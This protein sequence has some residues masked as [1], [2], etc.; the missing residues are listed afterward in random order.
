MARWHTF[1]NPV[2]EKAARVTAGLVVV[3]ALV[4]LVTRTGWLLWPMAL[5][6]ALRVYAGPRLSPFGLIS[7]KLVAPRLGEPT[8]VPGPPKQFAQGVGLAFSLSAAILLS[9]GADTAG[10]TL[11]GLLA[12]AA[13]LES[14]LAVCLGCLAFAGL[15]RLGVVPDDVCAECNDIWSRAT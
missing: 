7:T 4:A 3:T 1:P 15:I 10:W 6:F 8:V 12:V 14:V 2:N 5:G 13:T 11:V 9:L